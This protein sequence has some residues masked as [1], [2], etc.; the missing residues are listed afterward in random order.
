MGGPASRVAPEET[1]Q[2][3]IPVDTHVHLHPCFE[4]ETLLEAALSNF[5]RESRPGGEGRLLGALVLTEGLGED[6]FRGLRNEGGR[7]S[8]GRWSL[9]PTEDGVSIFATR[10][11]GPRLLIVAGRQVVTRERLEVL[12]LGSTRRYPDGR[13]F[14]D[15]LHE[16]LEGSGV[17]AVPWGFGKWW[18]RRGRIVRQTLSRIDPERV[19]VA[20]NGGRPAGLPRPGLMRWALRR[21]HGLLAGSDPLPLPWQVAR[22]GRYGTLVP[23]EVSASSPG[24]DLVELIRRRSNSLGVF[25]ERD[26][27]ARFLRAQ[28]GIRVPAS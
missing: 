26:S 9:R 16:T 7:R 4:L 15:S 12:V 21:G 20:D 14:R 6:N 28:V 17:C 1:P 18:F 27:F 25:G 22:A 23:G 5:P 11:D 8:I 10:Q 13:S 2:T 3:T 24:K 19:F